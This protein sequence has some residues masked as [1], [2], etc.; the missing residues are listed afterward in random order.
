[1]DKMNVR[2]FQKLLFK[3]ERDSR[4]EAITEVLQL[5]RKGSKPEMKGQDN[6][7]NPV[8]SSESDLSQT[9]CPYNTLAEG[10]TALSFH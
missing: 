3:K 1:M 6:L 8:Q 4:K 7:G 2:F 10:G 9:R 5:R